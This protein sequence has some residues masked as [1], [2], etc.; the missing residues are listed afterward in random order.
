MAVAAAV[1]VVLT[2]VVMTIGRTPAVLALSNVSSSTGS[3]PLV[4]CIRALRHPDH[5]G[6]TGGGVLRRLG[7]AV[8]M[9]VAG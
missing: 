3:S 4:G 9:I 2:L 5:R 6:F 1:I 7:A 8:A